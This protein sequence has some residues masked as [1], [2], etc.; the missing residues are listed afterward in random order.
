MLAAQ[1]PRETAGASTNSRPAEGDTNAS[2]G[3]TA[4]AGHR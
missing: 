1:V 4:I 3:L 2:Q